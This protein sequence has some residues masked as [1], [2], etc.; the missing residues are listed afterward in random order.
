MWQ[1]LFFIRVA[2]SRVEMLYCANTCCGTRSVS[3]SL[4]VGC[5]AV[6]AR[7]HVPILRE[8]LRCKSGRLVR[9]GVL[10]DFGEP[11]EFGRGEL[12]GLLKEPIKGTH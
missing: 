8:K 2:R 10:S 1:R 4:W 11:P 12:V 9:G 7:L 5:S 6:G 3:D